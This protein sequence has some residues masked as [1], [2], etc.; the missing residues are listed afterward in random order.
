LAITQAEGQSARTSLVVLE[1]TSNFGGGTIYPQAALDRIFALSRKRGLPVHVDGAR[2]WNAMVASGS[3][4]VKQVQAGGSISV[5]MS[6]G[7]GAPMGA[8]LLGPADFIA[9]ARRVQ[10]MLGGVMRQV[11]FMAAAALYGFRHQLERLAEDHANAAL[12]ADKLAENP[13]LEID[14]EAVQT[15]ILYL[16][17]KAGGERAAQLVGQLE[18]QGV[19]V[20]AMGPLLRLVTCLNVSREDCARAADLINQLLEE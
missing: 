13:A 3:D 9:E 4:P 20:L 16:K 2:V 11:G 7:L 8:L 18:R 19:R 10:T 12:L 1:N 17:V 15:N 6:K 5:C 14:R